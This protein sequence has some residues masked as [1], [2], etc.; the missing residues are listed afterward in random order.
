ML[1]LSVLIAAALAAGQAQTVK[2]AAPAW[3][4][5]NPLSQGVI[6]YWNVDASTSSLIDYSGHLGNLTCS[7]SPALIPAPGGVGNEFAM[8]G[9]QYCL[10]PDAAMPLGN[11]P[12]SVALWVSSK[13]NPGYVGYLQTAFGW[14]QMTY[15]GVQFSLGTEVTAASTYYFE[16]RRYAAGTI[17]QSGP[18]LS[19]GNWHR[20]MT[21]WDGGTLRLY[22]DGALQNTGA[23]ALAT[24]GG[25]NP[26]GGVNLGRSNGTGTPGFGWVGSLGAPVVWNRALIPAEVASDYADPWQEIRT[27]PSVVAPPGVSAFLT[28]VDASGKSSLCP[29]SILSLINVASAEA[30]AAP[31]PTGKQGIQ[32]IPGQNGQPGSGNLTVNCPAPPAPCFAIGSAPTQLMDVVS[33]DPTTGTYTL[34]TNPKLGSVTHVGDTITGME[35]F[36]AA[37]SILGN[38]VSLTTSTGHP[39]YFVWWGQ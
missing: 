12:W 10:A 27:V 24:Y 22:I 9:S 15:N 2:P 28:C 18:N 35:V 5:N 7:G 6:A 25:T 29:I 21:T 14:G 4:P 8:M 17:V 34:G 30:A 31:G 3:Q 39:L 11:S 38:V 20:W 19:D 33:P 26:I 16:S 36:P 13:Q 23:G 32:G 37:Y 1:K